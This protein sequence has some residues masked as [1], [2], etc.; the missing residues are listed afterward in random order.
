MTR[1]T[2]KTRSISILVPVYGNELNLPTTIPRLLS[3][4][5]S[6]PDMS[7]NLV[8]VDDGSKDASYSILQNAAI[9][10]PRIHV[11][12]LSKNFGAHTALL[13]GCDHIA[14]DCIA[15]IMADLQDPPELILEMIHK[16][17]EG[18]KIVIAERVQR[19]DTAQSQLFAK[20]FWWTMRTFSTYNIPKGGFDF[21]L[22]NDDVQKKMS[23]TYAK[24]SHFMIHLLTLGYSTISIPYIRTRRSI[25]KSK[26][27]FQKK[28]KLY[29]DSI[30]TFTSLPIYIILISGTLIYCIGFHPI[31]ILMILGILAMYIWR[32]FQNNIKT[33]RYD[34]SETI[35]ITMRKKI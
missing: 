13:A 20:I 26:W 3:I 22:F 17:K 10:D 34:I 31:L 14:S 33:S 9:A 18:N 11:L 28:L 2:F 16:W 15:I 4:L 12:Q 35:N 8:F 7:G 21:V 23:T 25:G 5:D 32:C 30:F 19:E 1:T 6:I 24:N 29:I 27:T